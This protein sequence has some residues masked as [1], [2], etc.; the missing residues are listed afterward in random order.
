MVVEVLWGDAVILCESE[1]LEFYGLVM[2]HQK[3]IVF[4]FEIIYLISY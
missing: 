2:F 1:L 3:E 4:L